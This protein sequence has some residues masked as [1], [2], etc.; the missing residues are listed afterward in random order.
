MAVW[1]LTCW[2]RERFAVSGV[3]TGL[4]EGAVDVLAEPARCVVGLC[5]SGR[6]G[7]AH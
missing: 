7:I 2:G 4:L 5:R 1:R 6:T 3:L